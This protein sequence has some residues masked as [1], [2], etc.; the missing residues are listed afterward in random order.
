MVTRD[1]RAYVICEVL[2]ILLAL[3]WSLSSFRNN[4]PL[5][6]QIGVDNGI[7]LSM[8]RGIADG[9]TPY[10]DITENKGP[11][12]FLLMALPQMV[13][14][15]TTGVYVLEVLMLLAN[16]AM[17]L[18]C[19]RWLA[20]GRHCPLAAVAAVFVLLHIGG[21]GNFC[22]EYDAFFLMVGVTAMVHTLAER[23]RGAG[24]RAFA[25]GVATASIALIKISDILGLGA[26]VLFYAAHVVRSKGD[27][28]RELLRYLGGIAVLAVPVFLYLWR[29]DAIGPML[30]EYILNNIGHVSSAKDMNFWELRLYL[31]RGS[32]GID[33]LKPV[34]A[35]AGAV[36]LRWLLGRRGGV[37]LPHE[38]ML[39]GSM[40]A[41]ALSN[42]LVGYVAGTGFY[43][44]LDMGGITML[45]ACLLALS[46]LIPFARRRAAWTKWLEYAGALALCTMMAITAVGELSPDKL[47]AAAQARDDS[48][49]AQRELAEDLE[50]V[51]TVYTIGVYP[52]WYWINGLQ[53]AYPY[54][55]IVGFIQDNVGE[56]L[57]SKFEAFL[58][59]GDVEALVMGGE[60]EDYR[61]TL[62]N[63][64][65]DY[66][67]ENYEPVTIDSSGKQ[68]LKLI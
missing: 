61:G 45:M 9:L 31:L 1:R 58:M 8:G 18:L 38:G 5:Y 63:D 11:L 21:T 12:F 65:V 62:T 40:S 32:Y 20:G 2:C 27:W 36:A 68:L 37:R 14:S 25:L 49:A 55:N 15:G 50:D 46:A 39:L 52:D 43:Q 57:E 10:V 29:V 42:L 6:Q 26:M 3:I 41:L 17:L 60:P 64:T 4:N 35:M 67:Q 16:C 34:F 19:A 54:Y 7:F 22:E 48:F 33:S 30:R 13:V 56:G 23:R 44:H 66:I 51:E 24:M 53:P 59:Q 47:A 28:R